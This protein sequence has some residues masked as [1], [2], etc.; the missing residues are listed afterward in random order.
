MRNIEQFT[1]ESNC[2]VE[3]KTF[4]RMGKY[5]FALIAMQVSTS[6]LSMGRYTP[7]TTFYL[8]A[9]LPDTKCGT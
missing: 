4:T 2:F 8:R 1:D 3:N 6:M 7:W 9:D 5:N